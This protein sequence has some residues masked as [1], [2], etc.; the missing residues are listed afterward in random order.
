[1]DAHSIKLKK[2]LTTS[3]LH[4]PNDIEWINPIKQW[5]NDGSDTISYCIYTSCASVHGLDRAHQACFH[6]QMKHIH[7][8]WKLDC[9]TNVI[10]LLKNEITTINVGTYEN[11]WK[12]TKNDATILIKNTNYRLL[13]SSHKTSNGSILLVAYHSTL[14]HNKHSSVGAYRGCLSRCRRPPPC[15]RHSTTRPACRAGKSSVEPAASVQT[16]HRLP[17]AIYYSD[18]NGRRC[19]EIS[20]DNV[21]KNVIIQNVSF[22]R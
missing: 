16:Q 4:L 9:C 1:M 11:E 20:N 17:S 13:F 21:R 10:M 14:S 18:P 22:V 3:Q 2:V 6:L 5:L 19:R 8:I 12:S 15:R 7:V